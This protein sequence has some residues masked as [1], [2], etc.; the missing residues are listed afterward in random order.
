MARIYYNE[1]KLSGKSIN[2][3]FLNSGLLDYF[4]ENSG[5]IKFDLPERFESSFFGLKKKKLNIFKKVQISKDDIFHNASEGNFYLPNALIFYDNEDYNFPTEFYFVSQIGVEVELR[6]CHGGKDVKWFQIPGLHQPVN[7]PEIFE[8]IKTTLLELKKIVAA[9][10]A[11]KEAL[12]SPTEEKEKAETTR[13]FINSSQKKAY[14]EL[15]ELCLLDDKKKVL[16]SEF[17]DTLKNYDKD[18]NYYTTLNFVLD[19]LESND[20]HFI[21]RMDWKSEIENL[22]W[23]M[24]RVLKENYSSLSIEL[25]SDYDED[26][27]VANDGVFEDFD[28]PLRQK[29]LQLGFIDTQSDEYIALIHKTGEKEKVAKAIAEIGYGYFERE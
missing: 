28:K 26:L 10:P 21:M 16:V 19:Y 24:Q 3:D 9:A 22:E 12:T 1:K 14:Q 25:P 5:A 13:P 29:G 8:K 6:K 20:V 17:I 7:D 2:D 27:C 18:E 11:K 15:A 4:F 23:L